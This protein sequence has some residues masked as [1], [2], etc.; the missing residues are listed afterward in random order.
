VY[1]FGL[2][3][4]WRTYVQK[5]IIIRNRCLSVGNEKNG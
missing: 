2:Y 1:L 4:Y 5:N 3:I